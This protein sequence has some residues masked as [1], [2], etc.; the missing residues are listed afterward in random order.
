MEN[1]KINKQ[2]KDENPEKKSSKDEVDP[3]LIQ[4][5][6]LLLD[7]DLFE[8]EESLV[9]MDGGYKDE[10]LDKGEGDSK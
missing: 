3:Q 2:E 6:D 1:E 8:N 10:E 7:M 4:N 5:L 9:F